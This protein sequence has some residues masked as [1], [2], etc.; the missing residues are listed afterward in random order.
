MT[1]AA[2]AKIIEHHLVETQEAPHE[3]HVK[4]EGGKSTQKRAQ[5]GSSNG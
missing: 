2:K 3:A 1:P 4:D 5:A